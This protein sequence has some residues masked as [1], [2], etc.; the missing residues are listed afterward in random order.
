MVDEDLGDAPVIG[1]RTVSAVERLEIIAASLPPEVGA[2]LSFVDDRILRR[3]IQDFLGKCLRTAPHTGKTHGITQAEGVA[4]ALPQSGVTA[5][6][7]VAFADGIGAQAGGPAVR[8]LPEFLEDGRI[9]VFLL[10]ILGRHDAA[11]LRSAL[12]RL[13]IRHVAEAV[14]VP[15]LQEI[16]HHDGRVVH[17]LG[18]GLV[19]PGDDV[20]HLD[21]AEIDLIPL[22]AIGVVG[23]DVVVV[24]VDVAELD[25]VAR[26]DGGAGD[27]THL[28]GGPALDIGHHVGGRSGRVGVRVGIDLLE[29]LGAGCGKHEEGSPNRYFHQMFHINILPLIRM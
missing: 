25:H 16:L 29:I 12:E 24:L 1:T 18:T 8:H 17:V 6:E 4:E 19:G 27:V 10:V 26:P 20:V 21:A 2:I 7:E 3:I 23:G 15:K 13:G 5:E 11:V 28:R 22:V 14:Q 9:H